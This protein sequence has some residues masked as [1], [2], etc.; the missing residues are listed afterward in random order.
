LVA[1]QPVEQKRNVRAEFVIF[2][3]VNAALLLTWAALTLAGVRMH[4]L[5]WPWPVV[6]AL[7]G[8]RLVISARSAGRGKSYSEE[9]IQREMRHCPDLAPSESITS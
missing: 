7:W 1:A 4:G 3:S 8:L 6:T 5:L 9:E 2:L